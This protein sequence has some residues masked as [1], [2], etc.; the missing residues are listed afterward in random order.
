MQ[1]LP[2]PCRA[3]AITTTCVGKVLYFVK[4]TPRTA[5]EEKSLQALGL[6]QKPQRFAIV[7]AYPVSQ[8][9]DGC[10]VDPTSDWMKAV[11]AAMKASGVL[12]PSS[13]IKQLL[14]MVKE[15][16]AVLRAA[17]DSQV[18]LT[19]RSKE[20]GLRRLAIP[21]SSNY[22]CWYHKGND[23]ANWHVQPVVMIDPRR[24]KVTLKTK[25]IT[26]QMNRALAAVTTTLMY[27]VYTYSM[28]N[29]NM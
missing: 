22:A 8:A 21:L 6:P 27:F 13:N 9:Q 23:E 18:K 4:A 14:N 20:S 7:E 29:L 3:A 16:A 10:K 26:A 19:R 2:L 15:R 12:T 25:D 17:K 24:A 11:V 5:A 1:R 28:S